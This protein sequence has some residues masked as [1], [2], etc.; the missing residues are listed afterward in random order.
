MK[1][2]EDDT[3]DEFDLM[4]GRLDRILSEMVAAGK[5]PDGLDAANTQTMKHHAKDMILAGRKILKD[6]GFEESK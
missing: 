2:I 3:Q 6:L 1:T 4:I 5:E